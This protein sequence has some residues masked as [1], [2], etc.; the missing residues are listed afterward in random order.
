MARQLLLRTSEIPYHI[1]GRSN[2]KDFFY[3]QGDT[4]WEIFLTSME[5]AKRLYQCEFHAFVMMSNHY[6]MIITTPLMNIDKVMEC[7]QREVAKSANRE[8]SRINHFFG[9]PYKW[10]LI[11]DDKYYWNAV[12]YVFRNPV[13]AGIV[14]DVQSY[15][16]SSLNTSSTQFKWQMADIFYDKTKAIELD[17]G[18]LNAPFKTE[19]EEGIRFGLRRKEFRIPRDQNNKRTTEFDTPR[20]KK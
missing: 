18:W 9:G 3:L 7:I 12:K 17:L 15:K 11:Y 19:T 5:K 13:R 20:F 10:S 2:N 8:V 14:N 1:T 4:L 16:Y 6:H